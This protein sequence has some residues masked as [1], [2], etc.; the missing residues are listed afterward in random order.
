MPHKRLKT[1]K[2]R[3]SSFARFLPMNLP[4]GSFGKG[5]ESLVEVLNLCEQTLAALD[6]RAEPAEP[7]PS[8]D[9]LRL[10][11]Q[12]RHAKFAQRFK[13]ILGGLHSRRQAIG[14]R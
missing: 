1:A 9:K 3:S 8:S 12:R 2:I 5:A 13:L 10:P 6:L 14:D 11:A 4:M 7:Q